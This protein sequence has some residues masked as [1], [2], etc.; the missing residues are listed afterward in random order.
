MEQLIV[1]LI[2]NSFSGALR[3]GEHT[4]TAEGA[5]ELIRAVRSDKSF[6]ELFNEIWRQEIQGEFAKATERVA[7]VVR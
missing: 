3:H 1:R 5:R 4:L 7:R 6:D 2:A